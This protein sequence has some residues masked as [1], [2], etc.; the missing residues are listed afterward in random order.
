MLINEADYLPDNSTYALRF[1]ILRN[2]YK[3]INYRPRTNFGY[4]DR[5][6]FLTAI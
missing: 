3:L 1:G 5:C 2:A 6:V 4:V